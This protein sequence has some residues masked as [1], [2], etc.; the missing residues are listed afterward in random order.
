MENAKNVAGPTFS[1]LDGDEKRASDAVWK[2]VR[3]HGNNQF[4]NNV[5]DI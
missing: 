5:E 1:L 2:M 4:K 3:P